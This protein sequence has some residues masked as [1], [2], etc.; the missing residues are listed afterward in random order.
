MGETPGPCASN[1]KAGIKRIPALCAHSLERVG[2]VAPGD[3]K[4]HDSSRLMLGT[5][6]MV[7]RGGVI[8]I[9]RPPDMATAQIE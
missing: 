8:L 2:A 9:G 7:R 3:G 5:A 1:K 6:G 4:R